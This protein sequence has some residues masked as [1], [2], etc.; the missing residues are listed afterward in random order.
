MQ[1]NNWTMSLAMLKTGVGLIANPYI[2]SQLGLLRLFG[3]TGTCTRVS[4]YS[5][6]DEYSATHSSTFK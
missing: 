5:N 4:E 1:N 2:V 3:F 6:I